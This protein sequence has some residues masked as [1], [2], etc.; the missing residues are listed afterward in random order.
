ML[1][2]Y[3]EAKNEALT[4]PD[5]SV[6]AAIEAVRQRAGLAPYYSFGGPFQSADARKIRHERFIERLILKASAIGI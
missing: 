2:N 5:A 3:A 4:A 6:Y 1:L